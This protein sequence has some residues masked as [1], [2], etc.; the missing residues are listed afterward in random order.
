MNFARR[1]YASK[2]SKQ[3]LSRQS[4]DPYVKQRSSENYRSRSAFKLIEIERRFR[5]LDAKDVDVV[6]DVG[7]APGGWSQVIANTLG[8]NLNQANDPIASFDFV[9]HGQR[10][11]WGSSS[12]HDAGLP[13]IHDSPFLTDYVQEHKKGRGVVLALD[14]LPIESIHG[15]HTLQADFLSPSTPSMIRSVLRQQGGPRDGKV[16]VVLSDM[17]PNLTGHHHADIEKSLDLCVAL[18]EFAKTHLR[19]AQMVRRR[20]AGVLV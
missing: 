4:S 9:R 14:L 1:G 13:E 2:S 6:V 8:W 7:A 19:P 18:I 3:W 20:L 11:A 17:A 16:D 15:V 10:S 5:I 12:E